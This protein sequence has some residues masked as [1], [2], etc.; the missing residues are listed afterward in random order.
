[1]T[2]SRLD[3]DAPIRVFRSPNF[4]TRRAGIVGDD[5]TMRELDEAMDER[6]GHVWG[7][8]YAILRHGLQLRIRWRARVPIELRVHTTGKLDNYVAADGIVE[9]RNDDAYAGRAGRANRSVHIRDQIPRPFSTEGIRHR[10][11]KSEN[12]ERADGRKHQLRNR[13]TRCWRYIGDDLLRLASTK[14]CDDACD[15]AL[16]IIRGNVDMGRVVLRGDRNTRVVRD[17]ASFCRDRDGQK[18]RA[19]PCCGR[20]NLK[21]SNDQDI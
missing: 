20:Q 4:D 12:R 16:K 19:R 14:C 21:E 5:F 1:L 17:S 6:V 10:R 15:E 9:R 7:Y 8:V 3:A 11:F 13:T 18:R 2:E